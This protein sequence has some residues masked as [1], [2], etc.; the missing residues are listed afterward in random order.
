MHGGSAA[1]PMTRTSIL[2]SW[3]PLPMASLSG[4]SSSLQRS[5]AQCCSCQEATPPPSSACG[6]TNQCGPCLAEFW[7]R[8]DSAVSGVRRL[9]RTYGAWRGLSGGLS[10]AGLRQSERFLSIRSGDNGLAD[11]AAC[12]V[13]WCQLDSSLL[14]TK[15]RPRTRRARR[16]LNCSAARKEA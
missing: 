16:T 5:P 9:A 11:A 3:L 4:L 12:P 8:P 6:L 10:H 13:P 7:E 14:K 1:S 15:V 2:S